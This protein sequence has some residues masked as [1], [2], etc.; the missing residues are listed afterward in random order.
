MGRRLS[1]E[2]PYTPLDESLITQVLQPPAP[3]VSSAIV[4]PPGAQLNAPDVS[5]NPQAF[6]ASHADSIAR[7]PRR[8]PPA[9]PRMDCTLRLRVSRQDKREFEAFTARFAAGVDATLK[10]SNVLRAM[11]S[12]LQNAEP[13]LADLTRHSTHSLRRPPNDDAVAYAAF[14]H[15][16]VRLIDSAVRRSPPVR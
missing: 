1:A 8:E 5:S 13:V 6:E 10:P 16:V 7:A 3:S 11:L 2:R 14:E 12:V 4:K 15:C 9:L